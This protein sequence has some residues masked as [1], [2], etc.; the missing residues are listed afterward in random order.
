MNLQKNI[1]V[2]SK[3][4]RDSARGEECLIR[5]PSVC[6]RNPETTV[7]CHLPELAMG[8]KSSDLFGAYGCSSCHDCV[9][10]RVTIGIDLLEIIIYFYEGI[11]RTQQILI[12][13]GLVKA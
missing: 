9:D 4:I 3:K 11:F 1:Q 5:I 6:N 7:F 2:K 13:K 12:N 8:G 10:G